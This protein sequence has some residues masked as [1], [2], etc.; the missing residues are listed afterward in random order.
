MGV[1]PLVVLERLLRVTTKKG[2][3]VLLRKKVH[4]RQNPGYAYVI[5]DRAM[6]LL[7]QA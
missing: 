7:I 6:P 3:Q 2:R 4:P 1:V 5:G